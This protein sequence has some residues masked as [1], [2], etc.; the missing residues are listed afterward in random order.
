[1]RQETV[2]VTTYRCVPEARTETYQVRVPHQVPYQA[3]RCVPH[4]VPVQETVTLCR[5]VPYTVQKQVPVE[6]CAYSAPTCCEGRKH[7]HGHH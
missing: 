1:M 6:T 2:P 7:G 4:S 5:M 3:T